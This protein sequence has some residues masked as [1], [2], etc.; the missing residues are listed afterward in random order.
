VWHKNRFN[1]YDVN[2]FRSSTHKRR[3]HSMGTSH[4]GDKLVTKTTVVVGV[5]GSAHAESFIE[6]VPV[7]CRLGQVADA[8]K[9]A[10]AIFVVVYHTHSVHVATPI[11]LSK[12][13]MVHK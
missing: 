5:D 2:R 8:N 12:L 10:Y 7:S 13:D 4:F 3:S 11:D 9:I 1:K 6:S